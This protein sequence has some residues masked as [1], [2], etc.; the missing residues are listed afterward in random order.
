MTGRAPL[1]SATPAGAGRFNFF[2]AS[3]SDACLRSKDR[4]F[5]SLWLSTDCSAYLFRPAFSACAFQGLLHYRFAPR[6][7][8][9]RFL[10]SRAAWV[11]RKARTL[12]LLHGPGSGLDIFKYDEG[13]A[14]GFEVLLGNKIDDLAILG[15]NFCQSFFK[16]I[17]L[18][19][20]FEILYLLSPAI[21]FQV[22]H[23]GLR[24]EMYIDSVAGMSR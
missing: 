3:A 6:S 8:H 11:Y 5:C 17:D 22:R 15:E 24:A 4:Q 7:R 14:L 20:L 21:S 16:L 13:L 1:G 19:A 18:D 12:D 10:R 2:C 23:R 9:L